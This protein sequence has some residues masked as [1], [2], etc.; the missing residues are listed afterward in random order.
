MWRMIGGIISKPIVTWWFGNEYVEAAK[1][2]CYMIPSI[3]VAL[4]GCLF[5]FPTLSAMGLY[6]ETNIAVVIAAVFHMGGWFLLVSI[7]RISIY[8]IAI[9][10]CCT[11]LVV[12]LIRAYFVLK[13][14]S[15]PKKFRKIPMK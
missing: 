7:N 14:T 3:I 13:I 15:V 10:T 6:K 4:P 1:V 11:E 5:G 12:V 2:V 9:L 8:S